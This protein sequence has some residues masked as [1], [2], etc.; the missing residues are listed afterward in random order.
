[1]SKFDMIMHIVNAI[2]Q[3]ID[4]ASARAMLRNLVENGIAEQSDAKLIAAA[5]SEKS[6]AAAPKELR[7]QLRAAIFKNMLL[8]LNT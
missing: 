4:A 2:G 7:G 3:T 6:L 1:M 8:V 5:L